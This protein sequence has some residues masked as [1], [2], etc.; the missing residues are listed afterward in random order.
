MSWLDCSTCEANETYMLGVV[1]TAVVF[2]ITS[3]T[4]LYI[5]TIPFEYIVP[6]IFGVISICKGIL[7]FLS[8]LEMLNNW[9]R[10]ELDLRHYDNIEDASP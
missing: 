1:N 3:A 7:M 8:P 4:F 9:H 10:R 6:A 2:E 5:Y